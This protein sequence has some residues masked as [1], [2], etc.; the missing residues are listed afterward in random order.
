MT[1]KIDKQIVG[2]K[3][4]KPDDVQPE[5]P[6][7]QQ[8]LMHELVKR[9]DKL[10]GK[11]YKINPPDIDHAVYI[12]INDIVL[13]GKTYPFEIFINSKNMESFQWVLAM[14]R[15]I[16]AVWRKGGNTVFLIDELKVVCSPHGGYWY[17]KKYYQSLV[18]HI[19]FIIEKHLNLGVKLEEAEYPASATIC[20]KCNEKA[21]ILMDGCETCLSCGFS[22]CGV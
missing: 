13:D 15:L 9:P 7:P 1:F 14:T 21:L 12:T 11:T 2:Y 4:I 8:Q 17:E 16:S 10:Q 18:S 5:P 22:K 20:G 19:G 6:P 3:V